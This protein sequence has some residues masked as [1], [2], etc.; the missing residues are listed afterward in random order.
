[1]IGADPAYYLTEKLRRW[2]TPGTMFAPEAMAEYLRC[3][4]APRTI[5]GTC[6][7]YRAAATI[8]LT[9]DAVDED[10]KIQCPLLVL[11]G[12]RGFVRRTGN[13]A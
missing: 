2:S 12:E 1:M 3:F 9:H 13:M 6:E 5:H 8:D 10:A 7:D 4:Q 11:W